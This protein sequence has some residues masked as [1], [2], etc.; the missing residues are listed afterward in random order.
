MS[1]LLA[2]ILLATGCFAQ[3]VV[4]KP[5]QFNAV[6]Q[7]LPGSIP[8]S[9]TC[10]V[11]PAANCLMVIKYAPTTADPTF[12]WPYLCAA[13]FVGTGQTITMTDGNG[14][15]WIVSGGTLG[16][17]GAAVGWTLPLTDDAR[18]RVFPGGIY[19]AAG[20]TGATGSLIFK[21]NK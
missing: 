12:G 6:G 4:N 10:I 20:T 5:V 8:T 13:D 14:I 9:G 18:C 21:Y 19:I 16:S 2:V 15:P 17:S 11:G 1:K 7:M 3:Q